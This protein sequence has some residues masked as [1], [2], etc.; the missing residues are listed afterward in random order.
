MPFVVMNQL[1]FKAQSRETEIRQ[2]Y[3]TKNKYQIKTQTKSP[4]DWEER[5]NWSLQPS[6]VSIGRCGCRCGFIT[7]DSTL[8]VSQITHLS[9]CSPLY[10][11]PYSE[12][13]FSECGWKKGWKYAKK[14]TGA[15]SRE[16]NI[17]LLNTIEV[18]NH[19]NKKIYGS[20]PWPSLK[21]SKSTPLNKI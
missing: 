7:P 15:T 13:G 16:G 6:C 2:M 5:Q 1:Q 3:I 21:N 20:I 4:H 14:N 10:R 18:S 8:A 9:L 11:S 19:T 17:L 12:V